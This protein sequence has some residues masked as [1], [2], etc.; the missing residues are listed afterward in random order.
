MTTV[1]STGTLQDLAYVYDAGGNILNIDD[2]I[3]GTTEVLTYTYDALNR[4]ISA[5]SGRTPGDCFR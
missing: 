3:D 1:T 4:L 2:D 5:R